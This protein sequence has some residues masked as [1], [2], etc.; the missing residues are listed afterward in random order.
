MQIIY[1]HLLSHVAQWWQRELH[2]TLVVVSP[3]VGWSEL[4]PPKRKLSPPCKFYKAYETRFSIGAKSG[5]RWTEPISEEIPSV[6]STLKSGDF[7]QWFLCLVWNFLRK[8]CCWT[9]R[10]RHWIVGWVCRLLG[11]TAIKRKAPP[12][13]NFFL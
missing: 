3:G 6:A 13:R 5:V 8:Q 11:L 4:S 9:W 1:Y 2:K 10:S 7:S 12:V